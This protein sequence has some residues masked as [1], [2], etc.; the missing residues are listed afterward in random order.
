MTARDNFPWLLA[1]IAMLFAGTFAGLTRIGWRIPV[2]SPQLIAQHGPLMIT[3]FLGTLITLERGVA[4]RKRPALLGAV[5]FAFGGI[6]TVL[7]APGDGGKYLT[8]LG[9]LVLVV[10]FMYILQ[11]HS[12]AYTRV[13]AAGAVFLLIGSAIWLT[14]R[15][16]LIAVPWWMAFLILTIAGERLELGR[17]VALRPSSRRTFNIWITIYGSSVLL[18][19]F[20]MDVGL[21]IMGLGMA[22]LALWHLRFDV[23]RKTVR[24]P[25][26]TR[27]IAVCMLSGYVWLLL[28]GILYMAF[29]R[30]LGGLRYDAQ[31]HAVFLGF[32]FSMIFGHAPI[33]FPAILGKEIQFNRFFYA[34]YGLLQFSL[35]VRIAGDLLLQPVLRQWGG[36]L[37]GI[38]LLFFLVNTVVAIL[39][40]PAR[41]SQ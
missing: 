39:F 28:G 22:A 30:E 11:Q 6:L 36:M 37:N 20:F 14:G 19:Y 33:I 7:E 5:F 18:S 16:V 21:R 2:I 8:V 32:V 41:R 24:K 1:A 40:I 34:H 17:L 10:I 31:L 27:F 4:L 29:G 35:L 23:A 9:S 12:A 15:P 26:L 38:A 3:G 13:M 25:G